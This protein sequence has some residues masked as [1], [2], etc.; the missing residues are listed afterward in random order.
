MRTLLESRF[1]SHLA[2]PKAA[3]NRWNGCTPTTDKVDLSIAGKRRHIALQR[4]AGVLGVPVNIPSVKADPVVREIVLA[5]ML[6]ALADRVSEL[7][8]PKTRKTPAK[9]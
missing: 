7:E 4:A 6:A 9:M 3:E 1:G 5:E 8:R 2:A